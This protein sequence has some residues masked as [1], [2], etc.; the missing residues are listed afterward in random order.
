MCLFQGK[1]V[2]QV[3]FVSMSLW[4][5]NAERKEEEC[6]PVAILVPPVYGMLGKSLF[7]LLF[8]FFPTLKF[9]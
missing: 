9:K 1:F 4:I 2:C 6:F 8:S 3:R 7:Q 5:L